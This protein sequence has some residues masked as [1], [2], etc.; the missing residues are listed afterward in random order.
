MSRCCEVTVGILMSALPLA[1]QHQITLSDTFIH[2]FPSKIK[3][4]T[5][6][7]K[8]FKQQ[9]AVSGEAGMNTMFLGR[10][11]HQTE[12]RLEESV[13]IFLLR[14]DDYLRLLKIINSSRNITPQY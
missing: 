3:S 11:L 6:T 14:E 4:Y 8:I 13:G 1:L 2:S 9:T 10:T 7:G 12:E 5:D